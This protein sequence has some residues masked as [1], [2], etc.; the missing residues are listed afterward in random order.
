MGEEREECEE[1]NEE[2]CEK[3]RM[4]ERTKQN[5][6][7]KVYNS[8]YTTMVYGNEEKEG[9]IERGRNKSEKEL[10]SEKGRN[11]RKNE[12]M[13]RK[14]KLHYTFSMIHIVSRRESSFLCV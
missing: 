4:K 11:R 8:N 12:E 6:T 3:R 2:L 10:L 14:A 5:E 9:K 1:R 7:R 13:E